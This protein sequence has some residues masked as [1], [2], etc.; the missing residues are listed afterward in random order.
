MA[1]TPLDDCF[2]RLNRAGEHVTALNDACQAI[3]KTK[4]H[5][6]GADCDVNGFGKIWFTDDVNPTLVRWAATYFG[7][8][9]SNLWAARNYLIWH[10]ACLRENTDLPSGWKQLGFPVLPQAPGP[11]ESFLGV[12]QNQKLKGLLPADIAKIEAVQPYLTGHADPLTGRL[13]AD[14][15]DPHYILEELAILD[16]HRRLAVLPVYPVSLN[17]QVN[18]TKGVAHVS[19][20][21]ADH[22]KV[23]QPLK[24]GNVVAT[25]RLK[26]V[27]AV[28]EYEVRPGTQVQIFPGDVVPANGDTFDVWVRRM[29][30]AVFDIVKVFE[31]EF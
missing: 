23:G 26:L 4:G 8:V 31:P 21:V 27:T 16:R 11:T 18:V 28:C 19:N 20:V 5:G 30:K 24:H 9:V 7:E 17:P 29:Q 22:S 25:F 1:Q 3:I 13:Q 12:T 2:I 14:P 15:M 10:L 6:F